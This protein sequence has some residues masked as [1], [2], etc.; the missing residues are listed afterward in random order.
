[1]FYNDDV[2][3]HIHDFHGMPSWHIPIVPTLQLLVNAVICLCLPVSKQ[4]PKNGNQILNCEI[5]TI[6]GEHTHTRNTK[7]K[8]IN[9]AHSSMQAYVCFIISLVT[10]IHIN[11]HASVKD[12]RGVG[13]YVSLSTQLFIC[14]FYLSINLSIIYLSTYLSSIYLPIYLLSIYLSIYLRNKANN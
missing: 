7:L 13:Y 14:L 2:N 3:K 8:C 10:S 6:N 11:G 1:M 5:G 4:S 12:Q 9:I